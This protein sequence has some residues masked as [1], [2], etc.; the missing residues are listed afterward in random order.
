VIVPI[1]RPELA[2]RWSFVGTKLRQRAKLELNSADGVT[3]TS[4]S[5]GFDLRRK[6]KSQRSWLCPLLL[7]ATVLIVAD[8]HAW[9]QG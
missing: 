8:R 2:K 3:T 6:T 7:L 9:A 4:F 5:R 1:L